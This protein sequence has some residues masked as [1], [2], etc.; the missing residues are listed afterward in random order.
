MQCI[1]YD[2]LSSIN[3]H[4]HSNFWLSFTFR[5]FKRQWNL[6]WQWKLDA[7]LTAQIR[8][9]QVVRASW[10]FVCLLS[11]ANSFVFVPQFFFSSIKKSSSAPSDLSNFGWRLILFCL[12]PAERVT[13]NEGLVL[14]N[15]LL[16][17]HRNLLQPSC[18]LCG[19][20]IRPR[21]AQTSFR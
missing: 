4:V 16:L 18:A 9:L 20:D 1:V 8:E 13:E 15:F 10:K 19:Y 21:E 14:V 7:K 2:V 12:N 5:D 11:A 6:T 3:L 17:L